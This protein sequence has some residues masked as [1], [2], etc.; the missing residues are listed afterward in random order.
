MAYT[1]RACHF[2]GY[3]DIQPNMKKVPTKVKSGSSEAGISKRSVATA[4]LLNSKEAQRQNTNWLTG[5]TKR[6][7]YRTREVWSCNNCN[8]GSPS[9][10]ESLGGSSLIGKFFAGVFQL[11]LMVAVFITIM[12]IFG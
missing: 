7:Y 9:S 4:M 2:C 6:Q 1:K 10:N 12:V 3:R 5:N 8:G 11:L